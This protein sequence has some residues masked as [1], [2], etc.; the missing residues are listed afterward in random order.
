MHLVYL[1]IS[2][3]TIKTNFFPRL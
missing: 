3:K 2:K 1:I